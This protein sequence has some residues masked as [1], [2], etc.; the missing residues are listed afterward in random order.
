M[1]TTETLIIGAGPTGLGAAWR[2]AT[3]GVS[4]WRLCEATGE[5]G[6]LAGSVVDEHG[7]TW[8]M[9]G[10]VQFSHYEYFD[11]L[12][13]EL[14]GVDG[15]WAHERESWIWMRDRFIPYPFQMNLHRLPQDERWACVQGL[16]RAARREW[17][18]QGTTPITFDDW[19]L[20]TFGEGVAQA[21]LRPYNFKVWA[22]EPREMAW[23]WIGD[24][25]AVPNIE[26]VIE[27]TLRERDDVSWGPNNTFRFPIKGGTG[28]IW[29]ALSDQLETTSPG[30]QQ[31][32]LTLTRVDTKTRVA[33]FSDGSS[34]RYERLL[35]TIPLDSLVAMS[36]QREPLKA[37]ADK[38]VF[39]STHVLGVGLT[40]QPPEA[41]RGK[42]WMYFPEDNCPFYRV[43]VFSHYA[44]ANVPDASRQWSLMAEVSE[45]PRKPVD[46][47]RVVED[48][49][50]G[51]LNTKL[52]ED[53]A[54]VHHV[55]HRRLNHGYPTPSLH[56]DAALG[57]IQPALEA[58]GVFSR[59][60]FG[61]WRYEVSNQDHSMA[62]GVEVVDRWLDGAVEE[63]L[64]APGEVNRRRPPVR[65]GVPVAR[66]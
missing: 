10:H 45:S 6:G 61:A 51:M 55:W 33:E 34:V 13:D 47:T 9:G 1:R 17:T 20:A 54:H 16:L 58:R 38:L 19:I 8:D 50:Q 22:Y 35:S 62:Q 41:L 7:F 5:A 26:R 15:W 14:L 3:R 57:T 37:A 52:I 29:R 18:G 64:Q 24:R 28:S 21:F 23:D 66:S 31:F 25:V 30:A 27:N 36:D 65:A 2:L 11:D 40:G 63:T 53:R 59:G 49:I 42:C 56:R 48:T 44:P 39:S 46:T 12:M 32:H 43:T 60:R 4:D